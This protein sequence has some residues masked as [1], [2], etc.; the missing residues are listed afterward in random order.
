MSREQV[1]N[2]LDEVERLNASTHGYGSAAF[3]RNLRETYERLSER[4][5]SKPALD[6]L[7]HLA[8]RITRADLKLLP[9][10]EATLS[11]LQRRHR[12]LLFTKGQPEEQSLKVERSGLRAAFDA[13]IIASEKDT[14]TYEGIARRYQI[15]RSR[16]WMIGNSPRSDITP[17][18]EAG[19]GA[20]YIPH[21]HT[22]RLER[23]AIPDRHDRLL[24]LQ[25]FEQLQQHF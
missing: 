20:V 11:Y 4:E 10:V 18:L 6:H 22:W 24:V 14:A 12:L 17:A 7:L 21:E 3:G 13:V 5:I 19:F 8:S 2:A 15:E 16:A 25:R 9:G 23:A 1:R